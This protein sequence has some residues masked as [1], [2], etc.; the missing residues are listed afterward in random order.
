MNVGKEVVDLLVEKCIKTIDEDKVNYNG[1]LNP[2]VSHYNHSVIFV[3][4]T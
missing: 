1:T 2:S 4:Y 3:H